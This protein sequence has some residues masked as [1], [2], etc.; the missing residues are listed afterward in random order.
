MGQSVG[1]QQQ[2]IADEDIGRSKIALQDSFKPSVR[3]RTWW[4]G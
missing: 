1:A 2:Y 4:S 3:V